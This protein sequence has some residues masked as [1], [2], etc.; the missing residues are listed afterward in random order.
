MPN[1]R[2][3]RNAVVVHDR[4][5]RLNLPE[6]RDIF[7]YFSFEE[8]GPNQCSVIERVVLGTDRGRVERFATDNTQIPPHREE[9]GGFSGTSDFG[10]GPVVVV[11]ADR[12]TVHDELLMFI[13]AKAPDPDEPDKF[14][15]QELSIA[16]TLEQL[17]DQEQQKAQVA[18][19]TCTGAMPAAELDRLKEHRRRKPKPKA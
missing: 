17:T 19:A 13:P 6:G 2:F 12:A 9:G 14:A 1:S 18:Q 5:N 4:I 7:A 15:A 3:P 16:E 8:F 10:F 11:S